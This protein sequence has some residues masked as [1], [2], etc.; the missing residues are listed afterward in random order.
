M[1]TKIIKYTPNTN[2]DIDKLKTDNMVPGLNFTLIIFTVSEDKYFFKK[3][4]KKANVYR[5]L[6]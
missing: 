4:T 1:C 2:R 6:F 3:L 5:I